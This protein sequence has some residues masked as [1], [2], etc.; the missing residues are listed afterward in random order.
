[1]QHVALVVLGHPNSQSYSHA[2]GEAYARGL[3]SA[4][5]EVRYLRLS[6]LDFDLV[7]HSGFGG[8]QQLEP[9]LVQARRA[10]EEASL[11]GWFFPTW[12]AGPPA[13]VKGF[14]DRVFLP[15]WAFRYPQVPKSS[16]GRYRAGTG[17]P[18]P[19]LAGRLARVVSSMDSP[20]WWYAIWHRRALHA[21]FVNGTLRFCGF[22][23]RSSTFFQLRGWSAERRARGL[24]RVE[25]I[26]YRDGRRALRARTALRA[27]MALDMN[28]PLGRSERQLPVAGSKQVGAAAERVAR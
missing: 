17:L 7:L 8:E 1:M 4:G 2:L 18:E 28:A 14:I 25:S 16:G 23:V 10:I 21:A 15:G 12:W 27:S 24:A 26:G 11:V 19:L 6:E 20:S 5:L 9:D 13:L 3:R 22:R